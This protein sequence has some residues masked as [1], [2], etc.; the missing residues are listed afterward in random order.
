M[1]CLSDFELYS[2]WVPLVYRWGKNLNSLLK[3]KITKI[4]NATG[5]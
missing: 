4:S 2:R 1:L 5:Y 3:D